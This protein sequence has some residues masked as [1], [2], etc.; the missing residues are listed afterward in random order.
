MPNNKIEL[1]HIWCF[2]YDYYEGYTHCQDI[3]DSDTL[4]K[5]VDGEYED[6]DDTYTYLED[7]LDGDTDI[8]Q[9]ELDHLNAKIYEKAIQGYLEQ[10]QST[11]FLLGSTAERYFNEEGFIGVIEAAE[12]NEISMTLY[13]HKH[14]GNI[15]DLLRA[16][17]QEGGYISINAQEYK[18][19]NEYTTEDVALC[20][21]VKFFKQIIEEL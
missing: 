20:H 12:G 16:A 19:L 13:E 6:G 14:D 17:Q 3:A 5:I 10:Q 2:V 21:V 8:A 7:Q 4:Q 9:K 18:F 11:Y 1:H 15:E